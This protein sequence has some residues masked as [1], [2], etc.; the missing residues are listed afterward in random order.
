[1]FHTTDYTTQGFLPGIKRGTGHKWT[2]ECLHLLGVTW[3]HKIYQSTFSF[4]SFGLQSPF[5]L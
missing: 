5:D 3:C 2:Q 1:M 4:L